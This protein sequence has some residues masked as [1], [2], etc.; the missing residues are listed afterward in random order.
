MG[1]DENIE[2]IRILIEGSTG[3]NDDG[4]GGRGRGGGRH[5]SPVRR[6]LKRWSKASLSLAM[7][8]VEMCHRRGWGEG[9]GCDKSGVVWVI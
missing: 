1:Y 6:S 4:R 9:V 7:A 8:R 2:E 5:L 3:G